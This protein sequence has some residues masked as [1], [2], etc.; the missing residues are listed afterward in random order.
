MIEEG[1]RRH[2]RLA[3]CLVNAVTAQERIKKATLVSVGQW[4]W[5]AQARYGHSHALRRFNPQDASQ[6]FEFERLHPHRRA[7]TAD[8]RLRSKAV[9]CRR[10]MASL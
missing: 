2:R 10:A 7:A 5:E 8:M 1:L 3:R 9:H 4:D 6:F